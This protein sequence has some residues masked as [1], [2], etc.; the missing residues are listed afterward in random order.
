[1][2]DRQTLAQTITCRCFKVSTYQA[3]TD[4]SQRL[5]EPDE[6]ARMETFLNLR[7]ADWLRLNVPGWSWRPAQAQELGVLATFGAFAAYV[8]THLVGPA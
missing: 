3:D 4:I 6:Q 1:M 8:A 7:I 2:A 5:D